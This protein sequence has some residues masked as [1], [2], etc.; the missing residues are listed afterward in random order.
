VDERGRKVV[1]LTGQAFGKLRV[2]SFPG[3][4]KQRSR[5]NCICECG[6]HTVVCGC[7]LKSGHTK[8]CGRSPNRV[9]SF[10]DAIV[11]WLE[12]K[13]RDVPCFIDAADYPLVKDYRWCAVTRKKERGFYA[14]SSTKVYMHALLMGKGA[15]HK[16][17]DSLNNRRE[18]LR[19]SSVSENN[20]NRGIQSSNM[21]GFKGVVPDRN[22]FRDAIKVDGRRHHLGTFDTAVEAARAYNEAAKKYHGEFAALNDVGDHDLVLNQKQEA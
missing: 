22:K 7:D 1:N 13:D 9:E 16:D 20:R 8:T 6:N 15:D 18:N 21:T 19:A 14:Q 10:G 4:F 11:I 2:E 12:M 3:V 17:G 5:W